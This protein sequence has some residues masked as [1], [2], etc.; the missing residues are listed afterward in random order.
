M[1]IASIFVVMALFLLSCQG[2][3]LKERSK[4]EFQQNFAKAMQQYNEQEYQ[5]HVKLIEHIER[6]IVYIE[7]SAVDPE[8]DAG[9][10]EE[11]SSG[12]GA[13]ISE[14]GIIITAAHVIDISDLISPIISVE[15]ENGKWEI[16]KVLY[17]NKI[18]D[19]AILSTNTKTP[20]YLKFETE[21]KIKEGNKVFYV[22]NFLG[23]IKRTVVYG[24]VASL[25]SNNYFP[26]Q[27][28]HPQSFEEVIISDITVLP[29]CS[30]GPLLNEDG[31][32]VGITSTLLGNK[33][34]VVG[35]LIPYH[36]SVSVHENLILKTLQKYI[37]QSKK[38]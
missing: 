1:R 34:P 31:N 18:I 23:D 2:C 13:V 14:D 15:F 16:A 25:D 35:I 36:F 12:T 38:K 27:L 10:L 7:I 5:N 22:G 37:D 6:S 4:I 19:I 21:K 9:I 28:K 11:Y 26:P 33:V 32:I 29:G 3:G 20:D 8:S 24:S 17:T 30:G